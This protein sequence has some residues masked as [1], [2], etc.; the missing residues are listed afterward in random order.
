MDTYLRLLML[1]LN[2]SIISH[3][4][5]L[6]TQKD[7]IEMVVNN[8]NQVGH[9]YR[10][11]WYFSKSCFFQQ[12]LCSWNMRFAPDHSNVGLGIVEYPKL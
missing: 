8:F 12:Y 7:N 1:G 5:K 10:T 2:A 9:G 3:W 11:F 4:C 6:T